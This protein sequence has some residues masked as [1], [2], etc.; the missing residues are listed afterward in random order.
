M[1]QSQEASVKSILL[2]DFFLLFIC[3][4]L[5]AN[6]FG[7]R[8][9]G[10]SEGLT[11]Y[12]LKQFQYA[13]LDNEELLVHIA[14]SRIVVFTI[15]LSTGMLRKDLLVHIIFVAWCGFAYGYFC[16]ILIGGFGVKGVL[17]CVLALFPQFLVYVPDYIGLE[18]ITNRKT[19]ISAGRQIGAIL[20]LFLGLLMGILLESYINPWI[21]QKILK[22]F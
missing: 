10:D 18:A 21:L 7:I 11:L 14:G 3:G 8:L 15:L 16:V 2:A 13:V 22:F 20:I 5:A 17:L 6:F 1:S 12:Y 19:F 9:P 4:I